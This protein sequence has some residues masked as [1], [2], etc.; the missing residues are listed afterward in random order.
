MGTGFKLEEGTKN[1]V[2]GGRGKPCG[3]IRRK[4]V[5]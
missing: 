5:D 1:Q 3:D 2:G 4:H